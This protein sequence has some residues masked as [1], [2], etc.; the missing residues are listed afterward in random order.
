MEIWIVTIDSHRYFDE[1]EYSNLPI[2]NKVFGVYHSK[3]EASKAVY[4]YFCD[5][6]HKTKYEIYLDNYAPNGDYIGCEDM[7]LYKDVKYSGYAI[8]G[9]DY[10][11]E[12]IE[13]K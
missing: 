3:D 11:L 8:Y 4:E 9:I 5:D 10:H 1:C 7:F 13:E 6:T 2:F 12:I